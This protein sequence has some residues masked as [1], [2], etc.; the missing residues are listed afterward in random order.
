M[1]TVTFD[2]LVAERADGVAVIHAAWRAGYHVLLVQIS[3]GA[4]ESPSPRTGD[5]PAVDPSGPTTALQLS[6]QFCHLVSGDSRE[7]IVE[8]SDDLLS[9]TI[10]PAMRPLLGHLPRIPRRFWS[11]EARRATAYFWESLRIFSA[12]SRGPLSGSRSFTPV[13][14]RWL[15]EAASLAVHA[16]LRCDIFVSDDPELSIHGGRRRALSRLLKTRLMTTDEFRPWL[17][18]HQRRGKR[19]GEAGGSGG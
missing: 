19:H 6:V 10:E 1:P 13:H 16:Y 8:A 3:Y 18:R 15:R 5:E 12:G 11:D 7:L 17:T 14:Q 2:T 9:L 4:L